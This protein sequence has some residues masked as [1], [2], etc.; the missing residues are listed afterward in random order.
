V[1][2]TESWPEGNVA[3]FSAGNDAVGAYAVH[4]AGTVQVADIHVDLGRVTFAPAPGTNGVL[5]LVDGDGGDW[6]GQLSVGHKDA[7]AVA[8][9]DVPITSAIN[10]FRYKRGTL[11]L[12]A[13]NT[14]SGTLTIEGGVVQCAVPYA[15]A[16][17]NRLVLANNDTWR[18][19]YH[20]LWQYTPAV[21]LSGGLD[22][23][24]GS[25]ALAGTDASVLRRIDLGQG[26]GTLS[27]AD[28]S[29]E[30][31]GSFTVSIT[32]YALGQ[33]RLRFGTNSAG[34]TNAQLSQIR[35][36]DFANLPGV[37][38]GSGYVTPNVPKITAITR[39]AEGVR[40]VWTAVNGRTYRVWCLDNLTAGTWSYL[41]D[42]A[43]T[44]DMASCIDLAPC[45]SG[46]FY[47]VEVLP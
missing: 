13:T 1:Q 20:T 21:F 33:S 7:N 29:A 15:L 39:L 10:V 12:G 18:W 45:P 2:A 17:T 31:W 46:R 4:V 22:Q 38:D 6:D 11:I 25:L 14:F 32:G 30:S 28:S 34:L 3:V 35:F 37:I 47:R 5:R 19:D 8:R 40:L 27:F 36:A 26:S 23:Q 43:A 24:L 41:S 42:V 9:Y 44:G 16:G